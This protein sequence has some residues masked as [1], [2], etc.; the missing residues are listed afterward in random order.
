MNEPLHNCDSCKH[1]KSEY[2]PEQGHVNIWCGKWIFDCASPD[3]VDLLSKE[4]VCKE[5]EKK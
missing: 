4:N 3:E 5:F 2:D 1:L